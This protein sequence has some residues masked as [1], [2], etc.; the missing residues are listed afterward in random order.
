MAQKPTPTMW[1]EKGNVTEDKS[2]AHAARVIQVT[3]GRRVTCD[4]WSKGYNGRGCRYCREFVEG[5]G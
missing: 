4:G 1:D 5:S 2:K 3:G